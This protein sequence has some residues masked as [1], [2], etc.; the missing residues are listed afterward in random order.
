MERH[1]TEPLAKAFLANIGSH[2]TQARLP[3]QPHSLPCL[4][5]RKSIPDMR[6]LTTRQ[7]SLLSPGNSIHPLGSP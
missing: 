1:R 4:L 2:R 3:I 7:I 5:N 6:H